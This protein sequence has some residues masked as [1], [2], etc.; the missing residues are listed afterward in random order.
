MDVS[1]IINYDRRCVY[2]PKQL[3]RIQPKADKEKL[4]RVVRCEP[5]KKRMIGY[6]CDF[7]LATLKKVKRLSRY[8]LNSYVTMT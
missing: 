5:Q 3:F 4:T 8:L 1:T 6:M 2:S 7:I